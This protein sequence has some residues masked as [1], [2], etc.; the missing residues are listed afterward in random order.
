MTLFVVFGILQ[1][2]YKVL[3]RLGIEISKISVAT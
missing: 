1:R 3:G 2:M